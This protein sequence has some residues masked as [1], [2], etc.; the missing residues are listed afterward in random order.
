MGRFARSTFFSPG[1]RSFVADHPQTVE[2]G[3]RVEKDV[4][5]TMDDLKYGQRSPDL[6]SHTDDGE[7]LGS[8]APGKAVT[9]S[10]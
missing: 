8:T 3:I 7:S 9:W 5:I 1:G 6:P 4:Q 2:L 10:P